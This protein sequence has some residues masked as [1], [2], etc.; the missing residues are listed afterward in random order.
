MREEYPLWGSLTV[1]VMMEIAVIGADIQE[2]VGS[3]IAFNLLSHGSIPI[4]A[5]C[6]ITAVDTLTFLAIE[7]LGVRYLEAF[8]C[9]LILLMSFCFFYNGYASGLPHAWDGLLQGWV[10]PS[11]PSYAFT[12]TIGTLG[13]VIMPHNLYLHSG[14]VL[15]RKVNRAS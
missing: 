6:L 10:V 4:W 8:V 14:L 13:A 2:V 9:S 11:M 7:Y 5:G 3:G 12:Q 1:Y 15:S